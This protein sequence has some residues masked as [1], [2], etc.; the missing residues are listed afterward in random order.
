M[1]CKET[2]LKYTINDRQI[3]LFK[4]VEE[5]KTPQQKRQIKVTGQV[6]DETGISVP[7]ANIKVKNTDTGT[8]TDLDGNFH[9]YIRK[10]NTGSIFHRL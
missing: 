2:G 4:A 10:C 8:I 7:G 5:E 6:I 9:H 3:T 1:L